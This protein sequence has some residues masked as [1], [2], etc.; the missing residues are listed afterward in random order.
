MAETL[1]FCP[2]H[3]LQPETLQAIFAQR[4]SG[5]VDFLFTRDNPHPSDDRG[6]ANVLH[7]YQKGRRVFL[8]GQ[9]ERMFV[10]E[11]DII[12]PAF[13]LARMVKT[14]QKSGA[15]VVYGLYLFR[16]CW[17]QSR[18]RVC[19]VYEYM[20]GRNVG[21]PLTNWP[22][23]YQ[24]AKDKG[25]IQCSGA[26]LGCVLINRPVL[27][28]IDFHTNGGEGH[29]DN[30]FTRDVYQAGHKMVADMT[31]ACGHV[32]ETGEVLWP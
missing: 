12:P 19:N 24:D 21:Q 6:M 10:V 32:C 7:N 31:V 20:G 1:V 5:G 9:Y 14:M 8:E 4:V 13:A 29:C 15:E 17:E 22:D 26:G 3:R 25:V 23:K 16:R 30:Y 28:G 27:E 11:N 18:Q 2:T